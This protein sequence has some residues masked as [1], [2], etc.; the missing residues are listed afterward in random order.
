MHVS[1][2]DALRQLDSEWREV[3]DRLKTTWWLGHSSRIRHLPTKLHATLFAVIPV[4]IAIPVIYVCLSPSSQFDFNGRAV[5]LGLSVVGVLAGLWKA[6]EDHQMIV[7][8]ETAKAE[9]MADRAQIL[10][11]L[12]SGNVPEKLLERLQVK[13]ALNQLD[14][15]WQDAQDEY[16]VPGR[17]GTR[18]RPTKFDAIFMAVIPPAAGIFITFLGISPS[19]RLEPDHI[20]RSIGPFLGIGLAL[21]S[22]WTARRHYQIALAYEQAKAAYHAERSRIRYQRK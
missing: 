9:Y 20:L 8:F 22:L 5:L 14:A 13:T 12:K 17:Y 3:Q 21:I 18:Y 6:R 16:T 7:A 15:A 11:H 4:V 1:A 10:P 19:S 2:N